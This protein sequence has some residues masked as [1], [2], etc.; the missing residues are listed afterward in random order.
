[1]PGLLGPAAATG[2]TSRTQPPQLAAGGSQLMAMGVRS[3]AAPAHVHQ[4][5]QVRDLLGHRRRQHLHADKA[6]VT[7]HHFIH[8][9]TLIFNAQR[10]YVY[11]PRGRRR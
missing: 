2:M 8:R 1:M 10:C 4:G 11:A 3:R 9:I 6:T 5:G 7:I